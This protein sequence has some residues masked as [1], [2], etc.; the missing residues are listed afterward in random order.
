MAR[1]KPRKST[2]EKV[3]QERA[4]QHQEQRTRKAELV[5]IHDVVASILRESLPEKREERLSVEEIETWFDT[6][7]AA[8]VILCS[9]PSDGPSFEESPRIQVSINPH[10]VERELRARGIDEHHPAW[11]LALQVVGPTL[12]DTTMEVL[13]EV[14]SQLARKPPPWDEQPS[15]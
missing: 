3:R 7:P 4:A 8:P 10:G 2:R 11:D 5:L 13:Q 15:E 1:S 14:A 9:M 6:D 12:R